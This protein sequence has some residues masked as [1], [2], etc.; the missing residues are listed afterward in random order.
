MVKEQRTESLL[1]EMEENLLAL[2]AHL[3][4][5]RRGPVEPSH[6]LDTVHNACGRLRHTLIDFF[7]ALIPFF[8]EA[9]TDENVLFY[10]IENHADLN[11]ILQNPKNRTTSV[12]LKSIEHLFSH[13]YPSGPAHLRTI[14]HEGYTRRGFSEFYAQ[15]KTLIESIEWLADPCCTQANISN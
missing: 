14:L 13:L 11:A 3:N 9:K 12:S 10:L 5:W 4:S 1:D 7:H 6:L 2:R 15:H 8:E